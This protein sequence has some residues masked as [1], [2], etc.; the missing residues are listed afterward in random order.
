MRETNFIRQ[1]K[2]KWSEFDSVLNG[3]YKDA[4]KLNDL[5][6]H[7]TDDLSYSR[8]FYPNRSV[9]VYLNGLAQRIFFSIYKNK[10]TRAGRFIAF[11]ADDVP[12]LVYQARNDLRLSFLIFALSFAIG[13]LSCTYDPGFATVIMGED[14]IEMTRS[15]IESGDPMAVYKQKGAFGMSL[16]I[17]IN[18]LYVAFLTFALGVFFSLGSMIMVA[19]TGFMVG[20]FQWFFVE[21][22]LF[23][24]SFLTIWIH[25]TLEISA[26]I[27]AGAAGMTV[28]RG[29]VFP[30]TFTRL[31][32]FQQ[33][34]RRGVKIMVGIVPIF[35]LAGFIEGYLTRFTE[36][37][38][39]IRGL[40]IAACLIFVLFYFVW[41]P[42]W[43]ASL[44]FPGARNEAR[45][46]PDSGAAIDLGQIKSPGEIFAE[47]FVFYKK[48]FSRL[49][50][51]LS[52]LTVLVIAAVFFFSSTAPVDM[53][54]YLTEPFELTRSLRRLLTFKVSPILPW[55]NGVIFGMIAFLIGR[56]L[57]RFEQPAA[58]RTQSKNQVAA[59]LFKSI[60]AGVA[61]SLILSIQ[62]WLTFLVFLFAGVFFMVWFYVNQREGRDLFSGLVRALSLTGGDYWRGLG[63]FCLAFCISFLFATLADTA[64]VYLF[65]ELVGW[66]INFE[67]DVMNNISVVLLTGLYLF[68]SY[69][70]FATLAVSGGILY[71]TLVEI[72]EAPALRTR[73][74]EIGGGRTIRGLERE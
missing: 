42:R 43:R 41:Y 53:F 9:R 61:F 55:A 28:G 56:W 51:I 6:V 58:G 4:D 74:E 7:I 24:E 8:T 47:T 70:L 52:G 32:A 3:Q 1:N 17:T 39:V 68:L 64:V 44:G 46:P 36:T 50:L 10:K 62:Y 35:I 19:R 12:E 26:I 30:G 31:Q 23:R 54:Y 37:P 34:A 67:Q 18:N 14:Y 66:I 29:L 15:N 65:F 73:M 2:D 27:I 69:L 20:A 45:I 38:D 49:A 25:G 59:D 72:R 40:F 33:S 16:G 5:F 22:G 63:L 21:Q 71:Y 11:W 48:Y 57:R 13:A 60:L